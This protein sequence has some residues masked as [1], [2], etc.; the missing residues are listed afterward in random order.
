MAARVA[1]HAA[2][3]LRWASQRALADSRTRL[4][5]RMLFPFVLARCAARSHF[6]VSLLPLACAAAHIAG[7]FLLGHGEFHRRCATAARCC[8]PLSPLRSARRRDAAL[9]HVRCRCRSG[10]MMAHGQAQPTSCNG[11]CGRVEH[12]KSRQQLFKHLRAKHGVGGFQRRGRG[13]RDKR[14]ADRAHLHDQPNAQPPRKRRSVPAQHIPPAQAAAP[15]QPALAAVA[16]PSLDSCGFSSR[17]AYESAL[18]LDSAM[19]PWRAS[20]ACADAQGSSPARAPPRLQGR[21]FACEGVIDSPAT[22]VKSPEEASPAPAMA[23]ASASGPPQG[24]RPAPPAIGAPATGATS[25][26]R[27]SSSPAEA[28]SAVEALPPAVRAALTDLQSRTHR[29]P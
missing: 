1:P 11:A 27:A 3:V 6:V 22:G 29:P 19:A 12:F 23:P 25:L 24:S 10:R 4:R 18:A 20:R 14:S 21:Q 5:A 17:A 15:V 28:S 7:M 13:S 9:N 16:Q 8:A 26:A 2:T